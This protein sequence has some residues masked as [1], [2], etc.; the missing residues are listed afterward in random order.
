MNSAIYIEKREIKLSLLCNGDQ[1]KNILRLR[2][3]TVISVA[4]GHAHS[5]W[6][7]FVDGMVKI[8]NKSPQLSHQPERKH[9][10]QLDHQTGTKLDLCT[11]HIDVRYC[12]FNR[13]V[14][15]KA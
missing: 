4:A 14:T 7:Y 5:W 6:I 11:E 3:T 8:W 2:S 13:G 9:R 15:E 1:S 10:Q 12:S